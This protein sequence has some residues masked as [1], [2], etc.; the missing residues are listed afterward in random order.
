MPNTTNDLKIAL[1][2]SGGGYRSAAFNLGVL[3]LLDSIPFKQTTL[4]RQVYALSTVSGGTFTGACYLVGLKRGHDLQTIFNKLYSFMIKEDLFALAANHLPEKNSL[5][6][7]AA[8]VY[9][10]KIFDHHEFGALITEEP[11]IHVK[12]F[13]F[14]ATEF[15]TG[16]QFRFQWSDKIK[17]ALPGFERGLIGNQYFAIPEAFAKNI[18]LSDIVAASS[19]FPGGFEP[20]NFPSDFTLGHKSGFTNANPKY[21][22]PVGLMD[23]G[24]SDNQGIEPVRL[25]EERLKL[26][27]KAEVGKA[28]TENIFDLIIVSD[29]TS[30]KMEAFKAHIE[31]KYKGWRKITPAGGYT[32][33]TIFLVLSGIGLVF[34]WKADC[35]AWGVMSTFVLTIASII[36]ILIT[37]IT[38][39]PSRLGVPDAFVP[40]LG[41]LRTWPM[42]LYENL[43]INRASS[44]VKMALDVFLK[45]GR[46]AQY[47][48][49]YT[50]NAWKNRLIMNAIYELKP[51]EPIL[52]T[53]KNNGSLD[54]RLWPTPEMQEIAEQ[55][56]SMGTTLWFSQDELTEGMLDNIIACGQFTMCWNLLEYLDKIE[57]EMTNTNDNHKALLMCRPELEKR[58]QEFKIDP[59]VQVKPYIHAFE[60]TTL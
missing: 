46:R 6:R 44:L 21:P 33:A 28:P 2:F 24:I 37:L 42:G 49:L 50:D 34:A 43:L 10:E 17:D 20:I 41:K 27:Y 29:V 47:N 9:D 4:L 48:N 31:G 1:T 57:I 19:C 36:L 7:A 40:T 18:K 55:S 16:N 13:S 54:K 8:A 60:K 23:G 45:G 32:W 38:G 3:T 25:A 59:R 11:A 35:L 5:I 53:K 51:T 12:H 22:F 30:P 52:E 58:W 14:N 26:N 15:A 39:L 56:S